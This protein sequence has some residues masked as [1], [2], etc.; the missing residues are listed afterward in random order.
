[1][2]KL[3]S[4]L[5]SIAR[6]HGVTLDIDPAALREFCES[7]FV[8]DAECVKWIDDY[9]ICRRA[10]G[11]CG[12]GQVVRMRDFRDAESTG[13]RVISDTSSD[14]YAARNDLLNCVFESLRL[15]VAE[16]SRS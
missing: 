14:Y 15:L 12:I 16:E 11:D 5:E 13:I 6:H 2:H 9:N 3:V 7:T 1:M 10:S 4:S 8:L